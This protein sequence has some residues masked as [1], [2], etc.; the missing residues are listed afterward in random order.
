M[1][2]ETFANAADF[3]NQ[4]EP[5]LQANEAANNLMYGLAIRA[6][7]V[8]AAFQVAP[9]FCVAQHQGQVLAAAMMTPPYNLVVFSQGGETM[10]AALERIAENLIQNK[11][12]VPGVLGPNQP[13][14]AF[15]DVWQARTGVA[16]S[17]AMHE[18]VYE[19]RQ[20]IPPPQ[21]IGSMRMATLA[22]LE[23]VTTWVMDFHREAV[24]MEKSTR[25]EAREGAR[26]KIDE[27]SYYV[28]E[29]DQ[30]VALAGK[31]RS[32]PN[33]STVGPVYTPPEFRRKGYATALTAAISQSILDSG[34]SFA[35]LFTDLSNP[36]SN[37]IY[38]KIGYQPVCDF[39]MYRFA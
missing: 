35:A 30:V 36:T 20:V 9:F 6:R 31:A 11:W 13:A 37:S 34:K 24:P 28:W 7:D 17:I 3:L 18:R 2:I 38:Q 21:P 4:V 19:L 8:P 27:H 23:L 25:D 15:A 16:Y 39:D 33:G 22:D 12:H 32:T 10:P 26:M 29:D 5:A 1:K 14:L